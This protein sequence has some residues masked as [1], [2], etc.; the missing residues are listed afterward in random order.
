[1]CIFY[2]GK[3]QNDYFWKYKK[4]IQNLKQTQVL[5]QLSNIRQSK[6]S[7]SKTLKIQKLLK[8]NVLNL[9]PIWLT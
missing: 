3:L 6:F 8:V 9:S 1:M 4:V 7:K 5:R 2:M